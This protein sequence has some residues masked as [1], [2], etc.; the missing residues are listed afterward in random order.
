MH[1]VYLV[2]CLANTHYTQFVLSTPRSPKPSPHENEKGIHRVRY[3]SQRQLH[4]D[5]VTKN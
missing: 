2:G 4:F 5:R 3:P 1:C